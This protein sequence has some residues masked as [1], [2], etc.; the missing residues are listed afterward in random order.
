MLSSESPLERPPKVLVIDDEEAARYGIVRALSGQGYEIQ[1][2]SDGDQALE[3]IRRFQPDV[4]LSDINM[5]AMDGLSLLKHLQTQA[6]DESE[7]PLVV[8]ITAYGS[9]EVAVKALRLGAYN[10]ISKPFEIADLRVIIRNAIDKQRLLCEN[11]RYLSRLQQTLAELRASQTALVQAEK[12][13]SLGRLVAGVAHEMNTPLGVLQSGLKT[14]ETAATRL[15]ASL[16]EPSA[17]DSSTS[18]IVAQLPEIAVQ[19]HQASARIAETVA[20]LREFAQLDRGGFQTVEIHEG[21]ENTLSLM[22]HELT[23]NIEVKREFG[24]IPE[25]YCAPREIN[26]V[27]MNLL[28]N[29]RDAIR[30]AGVDGVVHIRTRRHEDSVQIEIQ[31]NGSGI[32]QNHLSKIVDPGFTTKGVRVGVGLGLPICYQIL[33]AHHGRIDVESRVGTGTK[34]IITLPIDSPS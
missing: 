32:D 3:T 22:R 13:A 2:A 15:K 28:L 18:R 9:E 25:V 26:Q 4:V 30:H 21:I 31:D 5:P 24:D 33:Q 17:G 7:V 6:K 27:F 8:L 1:E 12:M 20:K 23:P 19:L 29:A 34:F 11:R 14:I 16:T 10:Y